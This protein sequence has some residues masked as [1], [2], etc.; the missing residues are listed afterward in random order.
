MESAQILDSKNDTDLYC[1]HIVFGP[2]LNAS[3]G[4]FFRTWNIH[5]HRNLHFKSPD[6]A[7]QQGL[8]RLKA[9]ALQN[10]ETFVELQQVSYLL[11]IA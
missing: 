10:H 7:F 5:K 4:K 8:L 9:Y 3:I 11:Y 6:W 2:L 1:L